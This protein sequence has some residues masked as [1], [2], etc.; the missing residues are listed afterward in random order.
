MMETHVRYF[1]LDC[2]HMLGV[3]C[4]LCAIIQHTIAIVIATYLTE[5]ASIR[6]RMFFHEKMTART[7]DEAE[8]HHAHNGAF[9]H[10]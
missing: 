1:V 5:T 4:V 8:Y 9:D 2:E 3:W 7:V 10:R 6:M